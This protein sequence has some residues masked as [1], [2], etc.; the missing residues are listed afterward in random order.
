MH[1]VLLNAYQTLGRS[2]RG[3]LLQPTCDIG[4]TGQRLLY[5]IAILRYELLAVSGRMHIVHRTVRQ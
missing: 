5:N 1:A 3:A 2:C 4:T